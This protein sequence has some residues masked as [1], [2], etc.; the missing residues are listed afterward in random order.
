MRRF[1]SFDEMRAYFANEQDQ[2]IRD[3]QERL[4]QAA[5]AEARNVPDLKQPRKKRAT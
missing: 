4:R 1:R 3:L 2:V 5:E